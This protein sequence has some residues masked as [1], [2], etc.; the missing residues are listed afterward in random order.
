MVTAHMAIKRLYFKTGKAILLIGCVYSLLGQTKAV[1]MDFI[2]TPGLTVQEIYSDNIRL[3]AKGQQ[4]S[5]FVTE[6]SPGL[7]IRGVRGGRLTANLDYR[8]QNLF[9]AGGDGSTQIFNQLKFNTA[10]QV[11]RNRLNI[12]ARSTVSQQNISNIRIGDNI[13]NLNTR[14]NV[15]TAGTT[16]NW[17]PHFGS[18]ANAVVAVNFDY[19]GN[20]SDN[21][22]SN[23][24]NMS[25]SVRIISGRD[26]KRFT[27]NIAFTNATNFRDV[28]DDVDF[29]NTSATIRSWIN[30]RFNFFATGTYAN[31]S[32]QNL[33]T[34][35]NGFAYTVG[36]QWKPSWYFNMEAGYGNNWHVTA[37]LNPTRRTHFGVGYFDRSVGLNTGGAW[38]ASVDHRTRR[39]FWQLTYTEDTTTVQQILLEQSPF[40]QFDANGNPLDSQAGQ[41]VNFDPS[42]PS[43]TN[44]VLIRKTADGSVA[45]NTGKSTFRLGAFHQRREYKNTNN[46]REKVYGADASWH[47]RFIRRT[48]LLLSPSWQ[49]IMRDSTVSGNS[50]DNRYQA[51]LRLTRAIPFNVLNIGRSKIL[52]LSLEYRFLQQN[53]NLVDNTYMENRVTA[54][55]FMNF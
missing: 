13:N 31:N 18:F 9:N 16:A 37:N 40:Q 4:Q 34:S 54:S 5:A 24:M 14:A 11:V 29:Q 1:A 7:S 17:T 32:F 26:F 27:W 47:W 46:D 35:T 2:F 38:N 22:L 48:S 50:K 6:I 12:A 43:F 8:M 20:D 23:S 10:Y 39:S 53:S 30:N 33:D 21:V 36:A 45:Y 41:S 3:A 49:Q 19:L 44:D 42:L 15:W 55:I 25:E 28:G 51:I 52:N